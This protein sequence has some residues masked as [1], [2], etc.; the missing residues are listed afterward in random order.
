MTQTSKK[1]E[2]PRQA[3]ER[4]FIAWVEARDDDWWE[5][6]ERISIWD[7]RIMQDFFKEDFKSLLQEIRE[8]VNMERRIM[9]IP[10]PDSDAVIGYNSALN[11]VM[12]ALKSIEEK[13]GI[14][15]KQEGGVDNG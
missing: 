15:T 11:D 8:K 6:Q 5:D 14:D 13:W 4:R 12:K 3:Q 2:T 1:L 7:F 10:I 9:A